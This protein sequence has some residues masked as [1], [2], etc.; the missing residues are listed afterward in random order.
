MP[1]MNDSQND[2]LLPQYRSLYSGAIGTFC[3]ALLSLLAFVSPLLLLIPIITVFLSLVTWNKIATNRQSLTGIPLAVFSL[4]FATCIVV[5]VP[6][7]IYLR[8]EVLSRHALQMA[9]KA[10]ELMQEKKWYELHHMNSRAFVGLDPNKSLAEHYAAS[11]PHTESLNIFKKGDALSKL[12]ALEKF[13]AQREI[14]Y[15]YMSNADSDGYVVRYRIIPA[16]VDE[17]AFPIWLSLERA[18][19]EEGNPVWWLRNIHSEDPH[20]P[21]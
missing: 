6:V 14:I 18:K 9:D 20:A 13:T 12:I 4:F 17:R 8:G 2:M 7:R 3:L 1:I 10:L 11:Q 16:A 5:Y 19:N 15:R 21:K